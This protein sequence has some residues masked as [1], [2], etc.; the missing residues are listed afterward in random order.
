MAAPPRPIGGHELSA[1]PFDCHS[2]TAPGDRQSS[3]W[4]HGAGT[5]LQHEFL[6]R[7]SASTPQFKEVT[8]VP[9]TA[10]MRAQVLGSAHQSRRTL[11]GVARLLGHASPITSVGSY[12]H[13]VDRWLDD[14]VDHNVLR[15]ARA[16]LIEGVYDLDAQKTR[17]AKLEGSRPN[18]LSGVWWR[19]W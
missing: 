4:I 10:T 8:D 14:Y 17:A 16:A 3:G 15:R 1:S 6:T 9:V 2:G 12:S 7:W 18:V 13:V 19:D 5:V 11:W